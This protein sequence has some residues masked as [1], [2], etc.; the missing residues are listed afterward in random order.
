MNVLPSMKEYIVLLLMYK[1]TEPSYGTALVK[2]SDGVL[3]QTEIYVM[4]SRM[5]EKKLIKKTGT[6]KRAK[7]IRGTARCLYKI[8][9]KGKKVVTKTMDLVDNE[10]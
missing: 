10:S 6:D 3:K 2:L 7:G 4:I 9:R 1:K 8:T 5:V